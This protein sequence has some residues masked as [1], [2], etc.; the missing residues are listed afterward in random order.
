M[1]RLYILILF[2]CIK[3]G[4]GFGGEVS[5]TAYSGF[6]ELRFEFTK[7][8]EE[9]LALLSCAC[10]LGCLAVSGQ[11]ADVADTDG[12]CVV[13]LAVGANLLDGSAR[14]KGA[15]EVDDVVVADG[16]EATLTMPAV[17]IGNC[18]GLAL[19]RC[20]TMDYYCINCTHNLSLSSEMYGVVAANGLRFRILFEFRV[21]VRAEFRVFGLDVDGDTED[22]SGI[23]ETFSEDAEY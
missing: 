4:A 11:S 22:T 14:V 5:V 18:E 9:R 8:R 23:D 1:E 2:C 21:E 19:C 3:R 16:V 20:R 12:R 17:Y 15:V 7:E 13:A 10:V 6:G